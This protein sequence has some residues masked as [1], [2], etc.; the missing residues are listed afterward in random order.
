MR[1]YAYFESILFV[2]NRYTDPGMPQILTWGADA[3]D[4]AASIW[5]N[6][7]SNGY[8]PADFDWLQVKGVVRKIKADLEK[9]LEIRAFEVCSRATTLLYHGID[10]RRKF[11]KEQFD[12]VGDFD[13]LAYWPETNQWLCI[14]CK[15]NQPPFCLKDTRRLRDRIFGSNS[16]RSQISKIERRHQ[17]M[18]SNSERL[19]ELLTGRNQNLVLHYKLLMFTSVEIFTG[20]CVILPMRSKHTLYELIHLRAGYVI[21]ISLVKYPISAP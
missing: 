18:L 2:R 17:F 12:D 20:G 5:V 9:Q 11:P 8:L 6:S 3:C 15:Y 4:R 16:Q 7:I 10:F 13:V 21:K 1:Q 14:E 19:R